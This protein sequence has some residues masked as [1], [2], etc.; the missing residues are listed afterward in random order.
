M[1]N[2]EICINIPEFYEAAA[3]SY[4][5]NK[6]YS[7]AFE[8]LSRGVSR[9]GSPVERIYQ[10]FAHKMEGKVADEKMEQAETEER[11][12]HRRAFTE[13]NRDELKFG[14]RVASQ[15]R[16]QS[17][18][19]QKMS[20]TP[21]KIKPALV[22]PEP[23]HEIRE[24]K[25]S[26]NA[27]DMREEP[28]KKRLR[29]IQ[30][31]IPEIRKGRTENIP[32]SERW[33]RVKIPQVSISYKGSARNRQEFNIYTDSNQ[34]YRNEEG[35]ITAYPKS[36]LISQ[37][38]EEQQFEE[39]RMIKYFSLLNIEEEKDKEDCLENVP[40]VPVTPEIVDTCPSS[41]STNTQLSERGS[42]CP[43]IQTGKNG[44]DMEEGKERSGIPLETISD[45]IR[46]QESLAGNARIATLYFLDEML[47]CL[48][49]LQENELIH[50]SISTKSFTYT[51]AFENNTIYERNKA[52]SRTFWCDRGLKIH[53]FGPRS[54]D[55]KTLCGRSCCGAWP[56]HLRDLQESER[57]LWDIDTAGVYDAVCR[58]MGTS[59]DIHNNIQNGNSTNGK[60]LDILSDF[61]KLKC[62]DCR[63]EDLK[64]FRD[65]IEHALFGDRRKVAAT[66]AALVWIEL[67]LFLTD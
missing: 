56:P 52:L 20:T 55:T 25:Q 24:T 37:T 48:I 43:R 64:K 36:L 35:E 57:W 3:L 15:Q 62:G 53:G 11:R 44:D 65:K 30:S 17:Y 2:R 28:Q 18:F 49:S 10:S 60:R 19:P 66:K 58:M 23:F 67:N 42:K 9:L 29:L 31:K 26:E 21:F 38:G 47:S 39:A 45:F 61:W 59:T 40:K 16:T 54:I 50:G 51:T 5:Y 14:F 32:T 34:E 33:S 22:A 13:L 41:Q 12:A 63:I 7:R 4:A 8:V 27:D 6:Q 46:K 1:E